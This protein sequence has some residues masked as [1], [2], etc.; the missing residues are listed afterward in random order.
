MNKKA[1]SAKSD[2]PTRSRPGDAH[3]DFRKALG[4]FPTGVTVVTA[5]SHHGLLA[6]VTVNS[7][8]AVSLEP[9]LV[10]WCLA[11]RSP[12][13]A[14]FANASHFAIHVL[15]H[16]QRHYSDRFCKPAADKFSDLE[17]E[18][19]GLGRAPVLPGVSSLFECRRWH[20]YEGGDHAIFVGEVERCTY[21]TRPPL[22]FH[23][24]RYLGLENA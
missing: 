7:F 18:E 21:S 19:E 8:S 5:R 12:S 23:G 10:L 6:G 16:D 2:G 17:L 20:K 24:G 15:A 13:L 3:F 11:N 1:K 4:S 9:P 22:L 14:I